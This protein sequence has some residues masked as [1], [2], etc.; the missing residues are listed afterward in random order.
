ML[1]VPVYLH[2]AGDNDMVLED[3]FGVLEFILGKIVGTLLVSLTTAA[4]CF[5]QIKTH[6][7]VQKIRTLLHIHK[8]C[9]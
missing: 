9:N 6:P 7:A 4:Y 8:L 2:I 1:V 3:T 5:M